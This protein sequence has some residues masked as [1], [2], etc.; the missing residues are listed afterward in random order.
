MKE[1]SYPEL[2]DEIAALRP[3]RWKRFLHWLR[4]R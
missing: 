1:K 4:Q 3:S 2:F